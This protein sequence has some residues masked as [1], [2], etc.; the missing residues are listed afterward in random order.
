VREVFPL[1][2]IAVA[3]KC[4]LSLIFI[5]AAIG[6][7]ADLPGSRRAVRGF[8]VPQGL[9]G[10]IGTALPVVELAVGL[11]L[12]FAPSGW[13]GAVGAAALL[14]G[15]ALVIAANLLRGKTPDCHC[16]GQLHSAPAGRKTLLRNV[17]LAGLALVVVARG[18]QNIGP[19]IGTFLAGLSGVQLAWAVASFALACLCF[20]CTWFM[21]QLYKQNGRLLQRVEALEQR[22]GSDALQPGPRTVSN[23]KPW[24]G[25]PRGSLAPDF[26]LPDLAGQWHS[27]QSLLAEPKPLMLLFT[28]PE[29]G[30]CKAMLPAVASW[31]AEYADIVKI[32]IVSRGKAKKDLKNLDPQLNVLVQQGSEVAAAF[33]CHGTPGAVWIGSDGRIKSHVVQGSIEIE[34]LFTEERKRATPELPPAHHIGDPAPATMLTTASGKPA[35]LAD[36]KGRPLVMLFWNPS[37]GFC[38]RMLDDLKLWERRTPPGAPRLLVVSTGS[39][40]AN[41]QAGFLSEVV[42]DEDFRLGRAFRA[43]GTPSAVLLDE[44]GA[45]SAALAVGED[46]VKS[47]MGFENLAV[48]GPAEMHRAS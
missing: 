9:A 14:S 17:A 6:K 20:V 32:V 46:A 28:D 47:L 42:L 7:L 40:E 30:P 8:G 4:L 26:R 22:P 23:D 48:A 5:I 18:P 15:F 34:R 44:H 37:C 16:F 12:L 24:V 36:F 39:A 13:W 10:A 43:T 33:E 41:R 27:L 11:G 19:G 1:L 3:S 25:L 21:L 45:V 35:K 29:C 38:A 31:H 2:L